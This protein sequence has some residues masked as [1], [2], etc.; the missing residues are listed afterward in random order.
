MFGAHG[1]GKTTYLEHLLARR[2]L[3]DR[4]GK[5][6][7]GTSHLAA[8]PEEVRHGMSLSVA[9]AT[10]PTDEGV[11]FFLDCPGEPDFAA[12]SV[13]ARSV[14]DLALVFVGADGEP[15]PAAVAGFR[16]A[17]EAGVPVI[18]ALTRLDRANARFD[19]AI[20]RTAAVLGAPALPLAVPIG[21]GE[22]LSGLVDLV[23][24]DHHG[25]AHARRSAEAAEVEAAGS[26]RSALEEAAAEG[27]DDLLARYLDEGGLGD[28]EVAKGLQ[29]RAAGGPAWVLPVCP[30]R[31]MG[32][33][34]LCEMVR[35]LAPPPRAVTAT[36]AAGG[37]AAL[38]TPDGRAVVRVF[39][40]MADPY[41]G[42][43]SLI[44]VLA[45]ELRTDLHMHNPA[46]GHEERLG[47][48]FH[49][50]GRKQLPVAHLGVGEVGAVAKLAHTATGD[51]L[52]EDGAH[53]VLLPPLA[54]PAPVMRMAVE[55]GQQASED[56][57]A[58]ALQRLVEEDPSL[59]V[60]T[61]R[62]TDELIL[63]GLGETHL[64]VA[65][66][67]LARKFGVHATLRLPQVP[68]RET[69][70]AH[71]RAEGKHKK[72]SG[73]HGQ[74]GHV[75]LEIEPL[76][77]GDFEFKD[78]IFGGVV[79]QQYRPAVEKGVRE[80]MTRGVLAGYPMTGVK[81]TL[82]DGSYHSVDSS[83]MAFKIAAGMAFEKGC[84]ESRPALLE[85]VLEVEVECP[86]A[87]AGAVMEDLQKKR[88]RILGLNP[89]D[90]LQRVKAH[91]PQGE[92]LRYPS[93]LRA[94]TGGWGRFTARADHYAE[95]PGAVAE[96]IVAARQ[97]AAHAASR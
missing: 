2:G 73:G 14:A 46:G 43:L 30:P 28:D 22:T 86:E 9:V 60:Y 55:T 45:G 64:D 11:L 84:K 85:P 5:V 65:I 89:G 93:E 4:L 29:E 88:A 25:P 37:E 62:D 23:R 95:A 24:R 47:Q 42:R 77:E 69:V 87:Y 71:A 50:T 44:R 83:E 74:Y 72:Q 76:A 49:V 35:H 10:V 38:L 68:Y 54:F 75:F 27:D 40:T 20:E 96:R 58:P 6:E 90:G 57:L 12:E 19:D 13:G 16:W 91:V 48:L 70:R 3:V 56:K 36:P 92:M 80:S 61:D 78:K 52:C 18:V 1:A 34:L 66:E 7:E 81:V 41:V 26:A 67:R 8:E 21:E 53:A 17:R 51:T 33:D 97:A 59:H 82:V 94:L 63:E 32:I 79:P 39:K 31:D 15:G